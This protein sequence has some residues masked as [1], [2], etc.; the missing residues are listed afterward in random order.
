M[1]FPWLW[2]VLPGNKRGKI[3]LLILITFALVAML[4]WFV[5]PALSELLNAPPS[6]GENP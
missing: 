6:V 2:R 3:L 4:F 5:F 1:I